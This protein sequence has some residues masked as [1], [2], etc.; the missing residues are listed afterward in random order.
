MIRSTLVLSAALRTPAAD[1]VAAG[2]VILFAA[3]VPSVTFVLEAAILTV[4]AAGVTAPRAKLAV[5][6]LS[7]SVLS[8]A[9]IV[10]AAE[11]VD[12]G[13]SIVVLISLSLPLSDTNVIVALLASDF[14]DISL[15]ESVFNPSNLVLSA[16]LRTPAAD[17]VAAG[18]VIL[19]AAVVPSV[20]FVLEAAILTVDAAGVTAPRAK[21]AVLILSN[22]VLSLAL[23]VPAAEEVDI[24]KS[25]VVLISLS[26]P[27]SDTNVIVA[28]LASDFTDISLIES[29]FNPSNLVLSA[30][31][32][33]PAADCVAAFITAV[34]SAFTVDD[35]HVL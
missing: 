17:C 3:V 5:L 32:R 6:I 25:I 7:N 20:T 9:L 14:T 1:C 16:A 28:L 18:S 15:I 31:L 26:L 33:T 22:S 30:A 8:L 13:K 2:S 21:L 24:G 19:F 29:V 27:L 35:L 23:I 11:E 34:P 10:P 4:D 12:I